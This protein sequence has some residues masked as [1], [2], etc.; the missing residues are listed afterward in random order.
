MPRTSI[1][2]KLL[3]Q[4]CVKLAVVSMVLSTFIC[5]VRCQMPKKFADSISALK[6][7]LWTSEPMLMEEYCSPP[8]P[9]NHGEYGLS[10]PLRKICEL[11]GK[12]N[13]LLGKS[14]TMPKEKA[15]LLNAAVCRVDALEAELISTKKVRC[16][17]FLHASS[18]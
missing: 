15:E 5:S 3:A 1:M 6:A 4:I 9:G 17:V 16:Y 11:E 12:V 13:M 8:T 14:C 10:D 18:Y 2:G 7:I